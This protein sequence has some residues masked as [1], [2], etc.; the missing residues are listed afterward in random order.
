M[1]SLH[2]VC[3]KLKKG[4]AVIIFPE[5][6]VGKDENNVQT[7][8][9]GAILMAHISGTPIVPVYIIPAKSWHDSNKVI[10]GEPIDLTELCGKVPSAQQLDDAA[11]YLQEKE[12]ELINFYYTTYKKDKKGV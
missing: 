10:V 7:F 11:K 6:T 8:K 2:S 12:Q 1:R 4:S 9:S 5:G 3:D